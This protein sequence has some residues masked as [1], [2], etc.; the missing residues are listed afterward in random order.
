MG[1][2][3]ARN[4]EAL[5]NVPENRERSQK[6]RMAGAGKQAELT[7][8]GFL[9][10]LDHLAQTDASGR[11]F[12]IMP[13]GVHQAVRRPPRHDGRSPRVMCL[14]RPRL[15]QRERERNAMISSFE[16]D[17]LQEAAF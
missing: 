11:E 9:P 2:S 3:S 13:D 5:N 1:S 16:G 4:C 6:S 12:G 14:R 15:T 7:D 8:R 17:G 10:E